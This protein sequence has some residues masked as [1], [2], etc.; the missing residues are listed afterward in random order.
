M[1]K[2]NLFV[3]YDILYNINYLKIERHFKKKFLLT[4]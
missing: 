1:Y 2:W 4:D 3:F